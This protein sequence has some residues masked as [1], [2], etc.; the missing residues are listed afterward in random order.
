MYI[1]TLSGSL[2]LKREILDVN[3][4]LISYLVVFESNPQVVTSL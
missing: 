4:N 2:S 1:K 3:F